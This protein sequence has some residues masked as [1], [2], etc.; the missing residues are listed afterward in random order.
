MATAFQVTLED[1]PGSLARLGDVLGNARVIT[2]S[3]SSGWTISTGP[4][5]SLG[6]RR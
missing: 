6:A 5:T 4:S 1:T 2:A 3:S